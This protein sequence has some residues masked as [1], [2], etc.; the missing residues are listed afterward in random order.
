MSL[1][2]NTEFND[3]QKSFDNSI[4]YL[5]SDELIAELEELFKRYYELEERIRKLE[6]EIRSLENNISKIRRDID[7]PEIY[8]RPEKY[9]IREK[10]VYEF[11]LKS[12]SIAHELRTELYAAE[13][14]MQELERKKEDKMQQKSALEA[15][16]YELKP[17]VDNFEMVRSLIES[18]VQYGDSTKNGNEEDKQTGSEFPSYPR[19]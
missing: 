15:E 16:Y 19:P 7:N 10:E 6:A 13:K 1:N 2:N 17:Y 12:Y 4:A 3:F 8:P 18:L 9:D 11:G 14:R 5:K